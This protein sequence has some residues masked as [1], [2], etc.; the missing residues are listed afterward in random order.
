MQTSNVNTANLNQTKPTNQVNKTK[1]KRTNKQKQKNAHNTKT[2]KQ[3]SKN[4]QPKL[5][6][7]WLEKKTPHALL[8]FAETVVG[9]IYYNE[10]KS[11]L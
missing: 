8:M 4:N 7:I 2:E 6:V 3:K 1:Q 10:V 5:L 9:L 11:Y